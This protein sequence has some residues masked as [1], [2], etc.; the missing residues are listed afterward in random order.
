M[1]PPFDHCAVSSDNLGLLLHHNNGL[2]ED[3]A[4]E[5]KNDVSEGNKI[6]VCE[7]QFSLFSFFFKNGP[8]PA[9]FL[10]IFGLF[11]QTIQF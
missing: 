10:F 11:K 7:K 6:S 4:L 2:L 8:T 1:R 9:S 3:I 5:C